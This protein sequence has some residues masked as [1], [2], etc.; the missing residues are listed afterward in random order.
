MASYDHN[1]PLDEDLDSRITKALAHLK[2]KG[3][4]S[5]DNHLLVSGLSLDL[6]SFLVCRELLRGAIPDDELTPAAV[7]LV[8]DPFR[9]G[10]PLDD[11]ASDICSA[12]GGIE[13]ALDQLTREDQD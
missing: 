13:R 9:Y 11:I 12:L 3:R 1:E 5:V 7:G 4:L 10:N 6:T 2:R 8:T